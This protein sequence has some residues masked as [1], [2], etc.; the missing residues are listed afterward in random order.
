MLCVPVCEQADDA[1]Q[2]HERQDHQSAV[3]EKVSGKMVMTGSV[4]ASEESNSCY[5]R[6]SYGIRTN[7]VSQFKAMSTPSAAGMA[8][9]KMP[10]SSRYPGF[11]LKWR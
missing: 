11:F 3:H 2:Y 5:G 9:V 4:A 1:A 8:T 10:E 7:T 6:Q